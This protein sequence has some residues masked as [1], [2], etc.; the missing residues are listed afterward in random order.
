MNLRELLVSRK[1]AGGNSGG[2][3]GGESGEASAADML[4]AVIDRSITE[5]SDSTVTSVGT[6]A[7]YMCRNLVTVNLP[8]AT[9]IGE[10]SFRYCG[11]KIVDFPNVTSVAGD[12]FQF[13]SVQTVSLPKVTTMKSSVFS[14]CSYLQSASLPKLTSL[15][16]N[17]FYDCYSLETI[18]FPSVETVGGAV[19]SGCSKLK[20]VVLRND[21]TVCPLSAT[22][23]FNKTPFASGGTGGKLVVPRIFTTEYPNATNWSVVIAWNANNKVLA[24]ED[25]TVDGTITGAID[26]D[27]LNAA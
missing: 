21:K 6:Y 27:K 7:F 23:S 5:V 22:S 1:L 17:V 11:L 26:W 2:G 18:D 20:V 9:S 4:R 19:F 25:F 14:T 16:S 8:N 24:L 15:P 13:S 10:G 12:A 3:G